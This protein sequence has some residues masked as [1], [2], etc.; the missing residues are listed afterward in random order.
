LTQGNNVKNLKPSQHKPVLQRK[1]LNIDAP[2]CPHTYVGQFAKVLCI[3]FGVSGPLAAQ[4]LKPE[5]ELGVVGLGL[6]QQ[7]YPGSS[8]QRQAVFASPVLIYR[9]D[10]LRANENGA[11]LRAIN[12]PRVELDIGF[13]ASLGASASKIPARYGMSNLGNL[14]EFG[15][16]TKWFLTDK[17]NPQKTWLELPIRG[18]FNM[19]ER[20][21]HIGFTAEPQ[22]GF[23]LN[24]QPWR[25]WANA[26]AILGD[27]RMN[28]YIYSVDSN[29][30]TNSRSPYQAK[31]GLM[32]WKASLAGSYNITPDLS[33]FATIRAN[34]VSGSANASSPL[35]DQKRGLN[36]GLGVLYFFTKSDTLVKP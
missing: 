19:S 22:V 35:I 27:S 34:T 6:S 14:V 16:R 5:W 29:Y 1:R 8:Y 33:L 4:E 11:G 31:A 26:G 3:I 32:A 13:S 10:F 17:N 23:E 2:Q 28:D 25:L 21:K 20:A 12:E 15:P 36:Y 18:V 30:A 9:G 7:A 24:A